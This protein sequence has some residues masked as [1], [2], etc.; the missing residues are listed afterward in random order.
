[1]NVSAKISAPAN[2]EFTSPKD[3]TISS[4]HVIDAYLKGKKEGLEQAQKLML[5]RLTQNINKSGIY[6][7]ELLNFLKKKKLNPISAFLK[8]NSWDS[9][10][11]LLILPEKEF[12]SDKII[13]NKTSST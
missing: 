3:K 11:V 10:K 1:M 7:T 4:D 13:S 8:I 6:T 12:L 2:W 5:D 9:F